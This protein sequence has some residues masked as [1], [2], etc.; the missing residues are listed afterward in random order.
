MLN[1]CSTPR[2]K[3]RWLIRDAGANQIRAGPACGKFSV[4]KTHRVTHLVMIIFEEEV[5]DT[6]TLL[7]FY[8]LDIWECGVL[9]VGN[10]FFR[11]WFRD[12]LALNRR[13]IAASLWNTE[14]CRQEEA[15]RT[16]EPPL[17]TVRG[18]AAF[19]VQTPRMRGEYT[20]EIRNPANK[21]KDICRIYTALKSN[22]NIWIKR[23]DNREI[24][25]FINWKIRKP[26]FVPQWVNV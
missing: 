17:W 22:G 8:L 15:A 12:D 6:V 1:A 16:L 20:I 18:R 19:R 13:R 7:L 5:K 10:V 23:L 21:N 2:R 25:I 9:P 14:G 26:L 24:N 4:H 3:D 11:R